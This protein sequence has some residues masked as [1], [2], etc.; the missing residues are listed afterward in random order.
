MSVDQKLPALPEPE[1]AMKWTRRA[2]VCINA[3]PGFDAMQMTAYAEEAC[4]RVSAELAAAREELA[5]LRR[6]AERY[7]RLRAGPDL[8]CVQPC[9]YRYVVAAGKE[10][11]TPV[12][13]DVLDAALDALQESRDHE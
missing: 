8:P 3:E 11:L 10:R 6:D 7:R 2:G 13:G 5:A 1:G 12:G 4:A 9:V